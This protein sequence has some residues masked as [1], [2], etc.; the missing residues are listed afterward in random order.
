MNPN[1]VPAPLSELDDRDM[2]SII[3][4]LVVIAH[5]D[6]HS[7]TSPTYTSVHECYLEVSKDVMMRFY[8][9]GLSRVSTAAHLYAL[10]YRLWKRGHSPG[11]GD[12]GDPGDKF[13]FA[14]PLT[15]VA[16]EPFSSEYDVFY[17]A[18]QAEESHEKPN[19]A[20]A[21]VNQPLRDGADQECP[22]IGATEEVH[23]TS[24][25]QPNQSVNKRGLDVADTMVLAPQPKR[26]QT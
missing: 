25:A 21:D 4:E 12:P 20:I 7:S 15:H 14:K 10:E 16:H 19:L 18:K 2:D 1:S 6:A 11:S 26:S 9:L 13:P 22:D 23:Q 24:A 17:R 8:N 3:N 5:P